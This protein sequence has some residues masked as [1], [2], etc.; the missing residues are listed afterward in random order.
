MRMDF[1]DELQQRVLLG[2]GAMGTELLAAGVPPGRCLEELCVSRPELVRGIHEQYLAAGSRVIGTNTFGANAVRLARHGLEGRV[3]EINWSAAQLARDA[4]RGTGVHVA[5]SVGPLGI[6]AEEAAA[7]GINRQEVFLEQIGALLDGGCRVIILETFLDVEELLIALNAKH[8]LHHCPAVAL[9]AGRDAALLQEAVE[10][11]WAAEADVVGVNCADG[12]A[13]LALL[14]RLSVSGP[15]AA[16]PNAGLP[17]EDA[18]ELR[19]PT[20]P[21]AFADMG[22]ALSEQGVR[23]LGGCC[24]IGPGHIAALAKALPGRTAAR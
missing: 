17:Q 5:G 8:T 2:D 9:L 4:V 23:L 19:Y 16:F 21:E 14:A 22:L 6:T 11:L 3:N 13:T 18:G 7:Q 1:L 10:K 20:T 24:G 12:S 15:L